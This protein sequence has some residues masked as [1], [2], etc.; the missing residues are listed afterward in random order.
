ME[1][2][3]RS[4]GRGATSNRSRGPKVAAIPRERIL[5]AAARLFRQRGYKATTVRDI[6]AE[7]GILSGSLFHH[8]DSKEQMLIE[9]VREAVI[10]MCVGAEAL[11]ASLADP[12]ERLR[13]L[14]RFE[15]DCFAGSQT[16]DY[17]A[18]LVSEWRDIPASVQPE[19][20]SMRQRY[21]GLVRSVV[22]QCEAASLLRLAPD[23]A[24]LVIHG[25][26]TGAVTWFNS[27]GRYSVDEF[28]R[29]LSDLVLRESS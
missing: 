24:G 25:A 4:Q 6:A 12:V 15:L 2:S 10:A 14:I 16:R 1:I 18:V 22:E 9:M 19:L 8:F 26:T 20:R 28:A 3:A 21:L 7:V 29:I 5:I 13:A 23:A 11:L 27:S 17:F